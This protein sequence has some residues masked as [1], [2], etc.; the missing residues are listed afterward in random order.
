MGCEPQWA[1]NVFNSLCVVCVE[2][3]MAYQPIQN[4]G[5]IGNM[6]SIALVGMDGSID[7]FCCPYFDS[8]AVFAA[9]LDDAKG[10]RFKIAPDP[11]GI[12]HKQ[13]YWPET[14]VLVTRFLSPDGV[15]DITDFMPIAASDDQR[16]CHQIIRRVTAL[17]GTMTFHL[18]CLPAFNYARDAHT[19]TMYEHGVMFHTPDLHLALTTTVPLEQAGAGVTARFTLQEGESAVFML[20]KVDDADQTPSL[21]TDAAVAGFEETVVYWRRWLA[22]CTY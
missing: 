17:R 1:Y 11:D 8:P 7:W 13:F 20:E 18:E 10:G 21:S 5:I 2:G 15:G 19:T 12:T 9:L 6:H 16:A 14:N 22:Q 3:A 4:Y